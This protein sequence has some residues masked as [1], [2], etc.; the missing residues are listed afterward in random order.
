M[1]ADQ[2][3]RHGAMPKEASENN[4]FDLAAFDEGR[5]LKTRFN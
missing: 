5:S 2:S 1:A 4:C 3:V